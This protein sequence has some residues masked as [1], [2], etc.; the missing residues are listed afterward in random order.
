[1]SRTEERRKGTGGRDFI[2]AG[3]VKK[4]EPSGGQSTG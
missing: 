1:M 4:R 3:Q 2:Q